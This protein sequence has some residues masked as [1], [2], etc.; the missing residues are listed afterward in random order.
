MRTIRIDGRS[1]DQQ[2]FRNFRGIDDD[3][4]LSKNV[5]MDY[6]TYNWSVL[7]TWFEEA[8]HHIPFATSRTSAKGWTQVP[9]ERF[10]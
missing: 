8:I 2:L 9:E 3:K 10:L 6:I 1:F 4:W 5:R 7:H